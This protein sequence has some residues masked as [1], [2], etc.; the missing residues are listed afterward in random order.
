MRCLKS[1]V[2]AWIFIFASVSAKAK[3]KTEAA[4]PVPNLIEE[5]RSISVLD[6]ST[7]PNV[8]DRSRRLYGL[9]YNTVNAKRIEIF[10]NG[11]RTR[12]ENPQN[13][14]AMGAQMAVLPI[15]WQKGYWGLLG[16]LQYS[17]L[18]QNQLANRTRLHSL[19]FD[20]N[21]AYRHEQ[22]PHSWVKPMAF[23]GGGSQ[24]FV[25]RGEI[26][27]DNTSEARG[28]LSYGL[29][30]SFDINRIFTMSPVV[31]VELIGAFKRIQSPASERYDLSGDTTSL[32]LGLAL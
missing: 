11:R 8:E 25:Q 16:N 23:L 17:L 10:A 26:D 14:K 28:Y 31:K 22:S 9:T 4:S 15:H 20:L 21:M 27:E 7:I 13:Q 6:E 30:L 24:V 18:E 29:G 2:V 3:P 5:S 32:G 1:V 12:Y 19:A